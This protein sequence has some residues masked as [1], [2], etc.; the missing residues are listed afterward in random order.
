MYTNDAMSPEPGSDEGSAGACV[1]G[2]HSG[3]SEDE[4][5]SLLEEEECG[6][7]PRGC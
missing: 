1:G 7:Q 6:R 5:M 3:R 4:K 2:Q